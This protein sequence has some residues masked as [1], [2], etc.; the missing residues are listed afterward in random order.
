ML[1]HI[2]IHMMTHTIP[3]TL[4]ITVSTMVVLTVNKVVFIVNGFL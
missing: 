2:H 1:M 3:N 4:R